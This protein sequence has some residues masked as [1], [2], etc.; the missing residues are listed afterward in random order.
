[1]LSF[2]QRTAIAADQ[3]GDDMTGPTMRAMRIHGWSVP[4]VLEQIAIPSSGTGETLVR[5]EAAAV[6]HL[7]ATVATG[8]FQLTPPLPYVGGVEGAGVVIESDVLEPGARVILRG[9]GLGLVRDG[10]WAEYVLAKSKNLVPIPDGLPPETAA[11]F[12]VPTTTAHAAL[13]D[14]ARLGSWHLPEVGSAADEVVIVAGAAGAVGS[15]VVQLALQA[16]SQV[17]GLVATEDQRELVADGAETV[18][19]TDAE[20]LEALGN[21]RPGTL[22]VDTLGGEGLVG[23][24]RFVRTGGRAAVVGYV[25]GEQVSIHLPSWFFDDVAILPVNMLR[26]ENLAREMAPTFAQML[27]AGTLDLRVETFPLNHAGAVLTRLGEGSLRGRAALVPNI[28]DR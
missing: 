11:T 7:D 17:I 20:R 14:I 6:S 4:P 3:T 18:T 27:V 28:P 8:T 24:A 12:F 1:M 13:H 22:L 15:M 23:R 10:T 21:T 5:V 19:S 9:G 26:R 25:T 16:G 2:V